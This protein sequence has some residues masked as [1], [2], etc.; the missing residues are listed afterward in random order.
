VTGD[1]GQY[2]TPPRRIGEYSISIEADGFKRFTQT[3]VVLDIGDVRQVN[4]TLEVGQV[5]DGVS[6]ESAAPLLQNADATVG[7]VIGNQQIE[8]LPM[9][10]PQSEVSGLSQ[11]PG[12]RTGKASRRNSSGSSNRDGFESRSPSRP[13]RGSARQ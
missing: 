1:R 3:R 2:R 5:S 11:H 6:V 9:K 13:S 12:G 7:T 10:C 8:I 4:A